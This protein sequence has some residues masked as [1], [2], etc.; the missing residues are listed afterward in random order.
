MWEKSAT[1][2][3]QGFRKQKGTMTLSSEGRAVN[4]VFEIASHN[5][6]KEFG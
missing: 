1:A 4:A 6:A 5:D 2:V 3:E